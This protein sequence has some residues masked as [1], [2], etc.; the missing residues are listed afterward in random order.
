[1]SMELIVLLAGTFTAAAIDVRTRRIPNALTATLALA[2]VGLRLFDGAP[3]LLV[4]LATMLVAFGVGSLA[5]STGWLGG[6]DVKL[7]AVACGLASF[8]GSIALVSSI[9]IAGGVI[10]IAQ[11]ARTGRLVTLVRDVSTMVVTRG[12]PQHRTLLPYGVAIAVGSA[13]YAL[14]CFF[15]TAVLP[16]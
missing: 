16:G 2:A 14:S 4:A 5:F 10:A 12:A 8:P 6:G 15:S 3:A 9:L 1:M 11:A 7:I 13:A